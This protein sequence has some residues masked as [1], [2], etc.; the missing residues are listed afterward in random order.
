MKSPF[1]LLTS[2]EASVSEM[3]RVCGRVVPRHFKWLVWNEVRWIEETR[4]LFRMC[5]LVQAWCVV[6]DNA[7]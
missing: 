5:I 3:D 4:L 1:K 2:Y 7:G 6:I